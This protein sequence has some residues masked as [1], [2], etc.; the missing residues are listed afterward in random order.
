MN[1]QRIYD[2]S[3]PFTARYCEVRVQYDF[4]KRI[5]RMWESCQE[6]NGEDVQ[7]CFVQ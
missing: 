3:K 4:C 6:L 7:I 1:K 5:N 2:G